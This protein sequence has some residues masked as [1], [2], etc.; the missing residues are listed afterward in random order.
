MD[1]VVQL[2]SLKGDVHFLGLEETLRKV[3]EAGFKA[4]ELG[5]FYGL[6][7]S[8]LK[9]L[10]EKYNLTCVSARV[11][12]ELF[13]TQTLMIIEY[14]KRMGIKNIIISS[15]SAEQIKH[16]GTR[17]RLRKFIARLAKKNCGLFYQNHDHELKSEDLLKNLTIDV[18]G[19]KIQ[20][21]AFW[22]AAADISASRYIA[23]NKDTV[24]SVYLRELSAEGAAAVNPPFGKGKAALA[25]TIKE[26]QKAG[27]ENIV[28]GLNNVTMDR[29]DYLRNALEFVNSKL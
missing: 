25:E 15:L 23:F 8:E 27:V 18:P 29:F 2:N 10:L 17:P 5:E 21:D 24:R 1:L 12:Y 22:S 3:S 16:R 19:L 6:L 28:I 14:V 11:D 7:P 4:V 20:L 9:K 13:S 26:A